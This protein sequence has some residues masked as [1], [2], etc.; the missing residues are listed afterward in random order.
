VVIITA[1]TIRIQHFDY[2]L[3]LFKLEQVVVLPAYCK[4]PIHSHCITMALPDT[5]IPK[6]PGHHRR[7]SS[8]SQ[9]NPNS[10][11]VN[12]R[13]KWLPLVAISNSFYSN[14][15]YTNVNLNDDICI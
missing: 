6:R 4:D 5:S 13:G 7:H 14:E 2:V 15:C 8:A 9:V 3:R 10:S 11:W 12:Y 1:V